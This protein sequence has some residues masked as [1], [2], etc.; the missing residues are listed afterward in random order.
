MGSRRTLWAGA[1]SW[2]KPLGR[3]DTPDFDADG[4]EIGDDGY[5]YDNDGSRHAPEW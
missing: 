4:S 2:A 1:T 3:I 5:V